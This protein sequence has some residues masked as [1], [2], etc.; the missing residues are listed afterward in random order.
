MQHNTNLSPVQALSQQLFEKGK[1]NNEIATYLTSA[2]YTA[3]ELAEAATH[4]K[5]LGNQKKQRLGLMLIAVGVFL[6][7]TGFIVVLVAINQGTS[8]NFA[9]YGMTSLG[10]TSIMGGLFSILG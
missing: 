4:L 5:K 10:A 1:S 6:C 8:F 9:L 3:D 7:V 2:G